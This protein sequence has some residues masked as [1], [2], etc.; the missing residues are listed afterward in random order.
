MQ[1][2]SSAFVE[3]FTAHLRNDHTRRAY[4]NA[5]A[6]RSRATSAMLLSLLRTSSTA[7]AFCCGVNRLLSRFPIEFPPAWFASEVSTNLGEGHTDRVRSYGRPHPRKTRFRLVT[8]TLAGRGFHPLGS[9]EG[10]SSNH[11]IFLL[12][13]L[14]GALEM[15]AKRIAGEDPGTA[16]PSKAAHYGLRVLSAAGRGSR[17]AGAHA[18]TDAMRTSHRPHLRQLLSEFPGA[19]H[20]R[21]TQDGAAA[22]ELHGQHLGAVLGRRQGVVVAADRSSGAGLGFWRMEGGDVRWSSLNWSELGAMLSAHEGFAL[23]LRILDVTEV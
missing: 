18:A 3:F 15:H 1:Q 2:L 4:A 19:V 5:A 7:W 13:A 11:R 20:F 10:F 14:P 22:A 23:E 21:G 6:L 16:N 17:L 9:K 8:M 12:Q